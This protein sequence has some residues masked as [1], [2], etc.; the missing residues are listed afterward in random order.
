[1]LEL[2]MPRILFAGRKTGAKKTLETHQLPHLVGESIYS[3]TGGEI[4]REEAE[5]RFNDGQTVRIGDLT[6]V[7]I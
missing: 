4:D 2:P 3:C 5:R 7:K 6:F 1:M